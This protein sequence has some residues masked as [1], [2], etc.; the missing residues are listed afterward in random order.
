[1]K[2]ETE[3]RTKEVRKRRM[4]QDGWKQTVFNRQF[5]TK[6]TKMAAYER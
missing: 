3:E 5:C 4:S 2:L 6:S 1:M